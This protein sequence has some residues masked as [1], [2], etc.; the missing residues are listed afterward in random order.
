MNEGPL[1]P[2]STTEDVGTPLAGAY[3]AC[4]ELNGDGF[5]D[6]SLNFKVDELVAALE[7]GGLQPGLIVELAVTGS[8]C[9]GCRFV[10]TDCVRIVPPGSPPGLIAV[11]S[12]ASEAWIWA[13][14]LDRQLDGGGFANFERSY[15]TS[16]LVTLNASPVV[17]GQ[18]FFRWE[19][20]GQPQPIGVTT[21]DLE[22]GG[23]ST[24]VRA[25]YYGPAGQ[26]VEPGQAEQIA[27]VPNGGTM[28]PTDR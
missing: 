14:P 1:G 26:Q 11:E 25:I 18:S 6:L 10:A 17:N 2:R 16:T 3:C 24:A 21:L 4:H 7:L 19:A 5:D 28:R 9:D 22:I 12:T 20:D 8:R 27:P 13:T 15:P 23:P